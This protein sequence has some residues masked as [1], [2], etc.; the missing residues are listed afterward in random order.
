VKNKVLFEDFTNYYNK[1]TSGMASREL[2][3]QRVTLKD[4]FDK[5]VDQHPNDV[6]VE[7]PHPF[8]LPSVIEQLGELY[9]NAGNSKALFQSSLTNPLINQNKNA[10]LAVEVI[11]KKLDNILKELNSIID[12]AKKPVAKR[13]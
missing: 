3:A 11:V 13:L 6:R 5:T 7:K 10:K 4:L 2:G 8:P 1:W 9:L 12:V